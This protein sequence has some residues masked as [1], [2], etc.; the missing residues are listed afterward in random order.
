[1]LVLVAEESPLGRQ[2]LKEL[3]MAL[4]C[5]VVEAAT[6][7]QAV[8]RYLQF[9]PH[10]VLVDY[11]LPDVSG[12][13]VGRALLRFNRGANLI[14]YGELTSRILWQAYQ[15]GFRDCLVKPLDR[16]RLLRAVRELLPRGSER[17]EAPEEGYAS[18]YPK[19]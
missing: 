8:A 13:E 18:V 14:L 9:E 17:G 5:T 10:L 15:I 12:L 6:G 7:M 16:R 11:D 19:P 1:M 3:L 4:G 2:T